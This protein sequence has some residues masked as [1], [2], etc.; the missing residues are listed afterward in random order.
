VIVL[1][2]SGFAI[3]VIDLDGTSL[4]VDEVYTDLWMKAPPDRFFSLILED[5]VHVP[6]YFV[7]LRMFPTD[8]ETLLRLPS[9]L[10]GVIGIA[11]LI[12]LAR[13]LYHDDRLALVAGTL[14]AYNPFH[15]W[16]SR[17]ARPYALLF[18]LSLLAS[19]VFLRIMQ[20]QRSRLN[21]AVFILS[22]MAAY[23]THYFAAALALAQYIVF[24]FF[25]RRKRRVFRVWIAAQAAAVIP[26]LIWMVALIQQEVVRM[27]ITW[28]QRPGPADLLFTVWN[29]TLDY[30]ETWYGVLGLVVVL[31]GLLPGLAYAF[32]ERQKNLINFYWFW[33][34]VAP[35]VVTLIFSLIVRPLYVDRYFMVSLPALLILTAYGWSRLPIKY[36]VPVALAMV[37]A[38][39]LTNVITTLRDGTDERQA[40]RSAAAYVAAQVQPDDGFIMSSQLALLSFSIYF[41]DETLLDRSVLFDLPDAGENGAPVR[42]EW[43]KPVT[44]LWVVYNNP[45]ETLHNEGVMLNH[46]PFD[47][48][49]FTMSRWLNER[50]DQ[51]ITRRDFNSITIFLMDVTNDV[52]NSDGF[53][54]E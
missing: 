51:I 27:N 9:A 41:D 43:S 38:V 54:N 6:L 24:A 7:I 36:A 10:Q 35:P 17:G 45:S 11:L 34:A 46:D 32:R 12:G 37:V 28:I 49:D 29:L 47:A 42:G 31:S 22:S 15:I 44:R 18:I 52:Y 21:W 5:G 1:L 53:G 39:G 25:L 48:E 13:R 20:G 50:R 14:L 2:L 8:G 16:F 23:L 26:L 19:Y 3:R 30:D 4:W 33:L 40:W